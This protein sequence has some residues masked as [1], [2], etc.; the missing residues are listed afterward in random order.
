MKKYVALLAFLMASMPGAI[1]AE[2]PVPAQEHFPQNKLVNPGY[3]NAA[4]GW[5]ASGGAT[6]TANATAKGE[7]SFG[8]D[9]DSNSAS[10]TLVSTAYTVESGLQGKNGLAYCSFKV[11]SGSATHT[12]TV[13]DGTNDIATAQT[14]QTSS[15]QFIRT[16]INFIFPS[17]G[18]V[19]LKMTSVAS[20]EPEIY[21]DGCYLG[22]AYNISQVSQATLIGSLTWTSTTACAWTT[23]SGSYGNFSN[24]TDCDDNARAATG[25]ASD[26]SA[27]LRPAVTLTNAPPGDYLVV[28]NGSLGIVGT[29]AS[30]DDSSDFRL[31]DG[32]TVYGQ[33]VRVE[34]SGASGTLSQ[35]VP[36][37]SFRFSATAAFTATLDLQSKAGGTAARSY[38]D[39]AN[40]G[41]QFLVYRFPTAA[42]A[43]AQQD[44]TPASWS[45]Y[46]DQDCVFSRTSSSFGDPTADAT[47][48]FTENQNRNFGTVTSYL[49]A[50]NKLPGI[51]FTPPRVGRYFVCAM[52]TLAG[53]AVNVV[54]SYRLTDGTNVI[55]K[56]QFWN[57]SV[58]VNTASPMCG[59]FNATSLSSATIR[60]ESESP[61][62][63]AL[64]NASDSNG[65]AIDWTIFQLDAAFPAPVLTPAT[66]QNNGSEG[67]GTTTLTSGSNHKQTTTLTAARTYVLPS[68]GVAQ[69]ETW[70]INNQGD[71]ALTIQ[72]SGGATVATVNI[73]SVVLESAIATPSVKADWI[74]KTIRSKTSYATTW[75]FTG[76]SGG[77][78]SGSTTMVLERNGNFVSIWAPGGLATSGTANT[79]FVANTA[80]PADFR[81]GATAAFAYTAVRN[82]G[83]SDNAAGEFLVLSTGILKAVRSDTLTAFTNSSSCG[84]QEDVHA[85]YYAP[86]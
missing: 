24:D 13:N 22:E 49:S 25:I 3:E 42:Q 17:S 77:G 46:H 51:V 83:G 58:A 5:T 64:I 80:M 28:V 23:T 52:P 72:A 36:S 43:A 39:G 34:V 26:G 30:T 85:T 18:S 62:N 2:A 76:G 20:N 54:Y 1:A 37:M 31:Y 33:T 57:A 73:G 4:Y 69:G 48:T 16:Q 66:S 53:S 70:E 27:G 75:G 14:I 63:N 79:A 29:G 59:I 9:W 71:F 15:T 12:F 61:T 35:L 21:I 74:V 40:A 10:Q 45:G 84:F 32:T 41:L 86:F 60:I 82:N 44:T 7:G 19:K 38:V 68:S 8:Y 50:G 81:P 47:C 55:A 11:P 65:H 78:T 67:A 56:T 6:K